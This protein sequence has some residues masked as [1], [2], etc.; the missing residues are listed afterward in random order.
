[1]N[2]HVFTGPC[3]LFRLS[4]SGRPQTS[5][6]SSL[7][8]Q[9]GAASLRQVC[10]LYVPVYSISQAVVCSLLTDKEV[11]CGVRYDVRCNTTR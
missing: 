8:L 5:M 1:M 9:I 6:G 7:L 3:C 10:C 2:N 11:W 4:L